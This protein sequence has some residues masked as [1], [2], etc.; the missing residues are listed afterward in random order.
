MAE[1]APLKTLQDYQNALEVTLGTL[2][3]VMSSDVDMPGHAQT[4]ADADE[5][6]DACRRALAEAQKGL[7]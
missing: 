1:I 4:M 7:P 5:W 3:D 2:E 6:L